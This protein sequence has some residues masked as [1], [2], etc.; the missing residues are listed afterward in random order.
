[1]NDRKET[2]IDN[3]NYDEQDIL[4]LLNIGYTAPQISKEL[5]V[6][7]AVVYRIR[8]KYH[9]TTPNKQIFIF[10]S[11]QEQILLSGILGDGNYKQNG[12]QGYY[13]R[14]SHAEDEYDYISWKANMLNQFVTKSGVHEITGQ[15][16]NKQRLFGF[17]T[18]TSTSFRQFV[19]LTKKQIIINKINLISAYF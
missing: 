16:F 6:T 19:F 13:Y 18:K 5:K 15:G 11:L 17:S 9:L 12:C 1:M 2:K 3:K 14:E 4:Q 8:R 7:N 10:N